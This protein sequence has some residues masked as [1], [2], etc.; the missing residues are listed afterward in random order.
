MKVLFVT[1]ACFLP[2]VSGFLAPKGRTTEPMAMTRNAMGAMGADAVGR[3]M[4]VDTLSVITTTLAISLVG[5]PAFATGRATLEQ[6]YE[7]Y[8][9]RIKAGG[10]FYQGEF[11]TMV[12]KGD[13]AAIKSA[14]GGVPPRKKEDLT[15]SGQ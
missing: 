6:S 11:K 2:F 12:A 14:T 8:V 1:S 15:A 3:R 13:W 4:F 7:R 5:E 9:P 10:E